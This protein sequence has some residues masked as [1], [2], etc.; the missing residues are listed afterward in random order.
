MN[1]SLFLYSTVKKTCFSASLE[2][3]IG[4]KRFSGSKPGL[5]RF[6]YKYPERAER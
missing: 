1:K 2:K 3:F 5:T 4:K 6:N